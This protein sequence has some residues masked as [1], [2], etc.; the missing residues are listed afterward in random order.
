VA[1]A[2][3]Q[4]HVVAVVSAQFHAAAV[5]LAQLHVVAVV[6]AQFHAAAVALAQL[7]VVAV[8]SAQ[9]HA[10]AV[11]LAQLHVVAVVS[12]QLR[13]VAL[14][15]PRAL[16]ALLECS[17]FA[18]SYAVWSLCGLCSRV[19]AVSLQRLWSYV[20]LSR[21]RLCVQCYVLAWCYV[22]ERLCG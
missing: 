8:V 21:R 11:A 12:A 4:L 22:L 18:A 2:L 13:V 19:P 6:S 17:P 10:A 7:H 20:R 14:A 16:A 15:Q 9:F 5:A 3:A 1:V